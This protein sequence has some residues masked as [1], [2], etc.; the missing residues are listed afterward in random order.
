[1]WISHDTPKSHINLKINGTWI[2][3]AAL[4]GD[5]AC[6]HQYK[7]MACPLGL[8]SVHIGHFSSKSLMYPPIKIKSK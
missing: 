6:P 4:G 7:Y 2:Y 5:V 8:C 3:D 1:M